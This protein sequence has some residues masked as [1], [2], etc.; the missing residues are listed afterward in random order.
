[1]CT[2]F[3]PVKNYGGA[4]YYHGSGPH[5]PPTSAYLEIKAPDATVCGA[6]STFF[7]QALTISPDIIRKFQLLLLFTVS[8]VVVIV[9]AVRMP[10][11]VSSH[12]VQDSRTLW[13][14]IEMLTACIV[15]NAPIL[16]NFYYEWKNRRRNGRDA[17]FMEE[18][19]GDDELRSG[20]SM[21]SKIPN[22]LLKR[23]Q[24]GDGTGSVSAGQTRNA[25]EESLTPPAAGRGP[26][27]IEVS[28]PLP[29]S[30]FQ[31]SQ[32]LH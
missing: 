30:T 32:L 11:I 31:E 2:S 1:M 5:C 23:P 19:D 15:A 22:V 14:S 8:F 27:V 20:Y 24:T 28:V 9:T 26:F 6:K 7:N 17:S 12:S 10:L 4:E 21:K 3:Y 13:A 25:S 29:N 18:E 16:N